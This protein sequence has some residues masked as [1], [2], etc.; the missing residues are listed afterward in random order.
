MRRIG[1]KTCSPVLPEVL[2]TASSDICIDVLTGSVIVAA[3]P[4]V[5][6][7]KLTLLLRTSAASLGR[8]GAYRFEAEPPR[9]KVLAGRTT[10]QLANRRI[11]VPAGRWLALGA[12][13][14][15]RK[16]DK[17]SPDP[18]DNWSNGRAAFLARLARQGT[19]NVQEAA[20]PVTQDDMDNAKRV[21]VGDPQA[22]NM[23]ACANTGRAMR[24]D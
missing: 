23:P 19:G 13:A 10:V 2:T 18:L 3:G 14:Y 6:G 7:T 8:D 17:R 20:P 24:H 22:R 11:S 9:V 16:F 4:M 1:T 5:K 12:M 15:I 21:F